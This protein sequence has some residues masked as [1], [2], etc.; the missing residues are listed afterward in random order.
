MTDKQ[1]PQSPCGRGQAVRHSLPG[2]A[3]DGVRGD[4]DDVIYISLNILDEFDGLLHGGLGDHDLAHPRRQ[5]VFHA[6]HMVARLDQ[7]PRIHYVQLLGPALQA[8]TQSCVGDM[9]AD[10]DYA[11]RTRSA[12]GMMVTATA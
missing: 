1:P 8:P 9:R 10:D 12:V 5:A 11:Q 4:L 6:H 7:W 2:L 3:G